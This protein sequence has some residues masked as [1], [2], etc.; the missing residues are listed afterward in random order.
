MYQLFSEYVYI[1]SMAQGGGGD[2]SHVD[3]CVQGSKALFSR[4]HRKWMTLKASRNSVPVLIIYPEC[5]STSQFM[6]TPVVTDVN[7]L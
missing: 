6:F 5:S 7:M 4:G 1:M 3:A 2:Q